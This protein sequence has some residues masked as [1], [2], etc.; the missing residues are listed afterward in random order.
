[1]SQ[2]PTTVEGYSWTVS[3]GVIRWCNSCEKHQN[4]YGEQT[5]E[6]LKCCCSVCNYIIYQ[7]VNAKG[8]P[9]E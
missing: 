8:K 9:L 4:T 2:E 3:N 6:G 5:P 1:M 7:L